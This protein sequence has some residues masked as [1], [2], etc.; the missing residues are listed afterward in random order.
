MSKLKYCSSCDKDIKYVKEYYAYQPYY[1]FFRNEILPNTNKIEYEY[2]DNC[3]N[4]RIPTP[5]RYKHKGYFGEKQVYSCWDKDDY[6]FVYNIECDHCSEKTKKLQLR[7][8]K[9]KSKYSYEISEDYHLIIALCNNCNKIHPKQVFK[10]KI[11]E[12]CVKI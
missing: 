2:C 8:A 11:N 7:L 5:T 6:G 12:F 1:L 3:F 10:P 4:Y 9:F